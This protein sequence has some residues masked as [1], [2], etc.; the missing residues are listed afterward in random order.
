MNGTVV[1]TSGSL[2]ILE[3]STYSEGFNTV[4]GNIININLME[5]SLETINGI[6]GNI[7]SIT[8]S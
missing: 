1:A 2:T 7:T 3:L 8:L 5:S 4:G 6:T